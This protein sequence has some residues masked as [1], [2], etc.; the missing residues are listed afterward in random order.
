MKKQ[1]YQNH[2]RYYIPHHFVFYPVTG[3]CIALCIYYMTQYPEKKLEFGLLAGC[4]FVVAWLSFMLRQHYALTNQD[5][6][7]RLELRLRYYQLTGKRLEEL[8]SKLSFKQ[9]AAAR[10][11]NDDQFVELLQQAVDNNLS[12]DEMKK[13]IRVWN[14][15]T[16]RV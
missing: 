9:L 4:F 13:R 7:V 12:P 3:A 8:E 10:F 14:A 16:M 15:D 1:N 6:I 11:A 2:I 5:R